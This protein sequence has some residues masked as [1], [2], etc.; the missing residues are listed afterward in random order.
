[1]NELIAR[2]PRLWLSRSWT[3]RARRPSEAADA[4]VFVDRPAFEAH[5]DSG[6][7]LEWTELP[8]NGC[9]Y[10]TPWPDPPAGRDLVL[11]IDLDGAR[12]VRERRPEAVILLIEPPSWEELERRLRGRGDPESQVRSRLELAEVEVHEGRKLADA[13][14]VNDSLARATAEVAGILARYRTSPPGLSGTDAPKET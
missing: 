14:V 1:M 12:Q 10:G 7:F 6:G 3:T 2:D 4:Y 8:A 5:R 11:E 9:L 13:V